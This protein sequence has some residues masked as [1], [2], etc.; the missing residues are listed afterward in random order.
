MS[1]SEHKP[2]QRILLVIA[3][4]GA[5]GAERQMA[6]LARGLDRSR[7]DV[8]LLIFNSDDK[9]NY[10][11]VVAS[12]IWFR[13]LG[14]SRGRDTKL[15]IAMGLI[16]GI[17]RAVADF[18]P[19]LIHTSLYVAGVAV[20][21]SSLFLFPRI[22]LITSSIRADFI[23]YYSSWH[24]FTERIL[25]RR[26]ACI[27]TNAEFIRRQLLKH[28]PIPSSRVIKVENGID[29]RFSIGFSESPDDWPA[30]GRIGL[31]V[32]RFTPEKNHLALIKALKTLDEKDLL[33]DWSFV[34]VGEG[35]LRAQ[36]EMAVL[37]FSRI[38]LF[39]KSSDLLPFYRNA[40]LLLHPSLNEGMANVLLEAQ[41]CGVPVAV[42]KSANASGVVTEGTGFILSDELSS[43]LGRV[44]GTP[45]KVLKCRGKAAHQY[46]TDRYGAERMIKQTERVYQKVIQS[47]VLNN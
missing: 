15:G 35:P 17:R 44:L 28:L 32:G 3:G 9:I 33:D 38:K 42:T 40:D 30:D 45:S 21:V 43:A 2:R 14:F 13:A 29:P 1:N 7:Y 11:E 39:S 23:K 36:I 10:R 24:R 19:D 18:Q 20:R 34:I 46:V 8:G 25:C 12:S 22:P 26:S 41:A 5:G 6:L 16:R 27:V 37:N 31:V 47:S 4:L